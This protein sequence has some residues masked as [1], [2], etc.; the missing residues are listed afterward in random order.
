MIERQA[1]R[2]ILLTPDREVLLMRIRIPDVPAPFW[3]CPGGG[4]E[5][6]EELL[7]TLRRELKEELGLENFGLGPL[8]W[9]RR[10]TFNFKDKR[11]CQ[12]E[13]Y[14][15]VNVDK[16][17]PVITD[18]VEMEVFEE[19][20]WFSVAQLKDFSERVTPLSLAQIVEDYLRNGPP[21]GRL[22]LEVLMD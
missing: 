10:H 8:V 18:P 21:K 15:V 17:D 3:I 9:R 5:A 2:A 22:A 13:S 12:T 19:F 6:G 11:L 14:H 4:M 20:R 7:P 16:F 1:V